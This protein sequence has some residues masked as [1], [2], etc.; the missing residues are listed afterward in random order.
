MMECPS[1]G[2]PTINAST[3]LI[4]DTCGHTKCR[5][6]LLQEES[7]CTICN[8][9]NLEQ[10]APL[11][12]AISSFDYLQP[13]IPMP[14]HV[15]LDS[16][17][18]LPVNELPQVIECLDEPF[19]VKYVIDNNTNN[20]IYKET[21]SENEKYYEENNKQIYNEARQNVHLAFES[22]E[23]VLSHNGLS[24]QNGLTITNNIKNENIHRKDVETQ[25]KQSN[26]NSDEQT[27]TVK[28]LV[29]N[30]VN[31]EVATNQSN[32]TFVLLID[33]NSPTRNDSESTVQITKINKNEDEN[34]DN[35]LP[36]KTPNQLV[37]YKSPEFRMSDYLLFNKQGESPDY[38]LVHKSGD[39]ENDHQLI[40]SPAHSTAY[41][42][43]EFRLSDYLIIKN[44]SD[45]TTYAR[46]IASPIESFDNRV[47]G[48]STVQSNGNKAGDSLNKD[49]EDKENKNNSIKEKDTGSD[50]VIG[51]H[52]KKNR[53]K[54][55]IQTKS[56]KTKKSDTLSS[57]RKSTR[58]R[59]LTAA[60]KDLED[61]VTKNTA[62]KRRKKNTDWSHI[63]KLPGNPVSYE[64]TKCK[65]SFRNFQSKSYHVACILGESPFCCEICGRTFKKRSHFEYHE[66]THSGKKPFMCQDC[67]KGFATK[68]KLDRHML[69]H[70]PQNE[71]ECAEC[72]KKL[73]TKDNL[74]THLALHRNPSFKC[75]HC[76]K[77]FTLKINRKRH[78]QYCFPNNNRYTCDVCSKVFRKDYLL[79][80]HKRR[81]HRKGKPYSCKVCQRVFLSKS[82]VAR[83][84]TIHSDV[85]AFYCELCDIKFRRKDNLK[86]HENNHH[87]S[88]YEVGYGNVTPISVKEYVVAPSPIP[89]GRK[90]QAVDSSELSP[91][92]KRTPKKVK[93]MDSPSKL[94]AASSGDVS[95]AVP[96]IRG[97]ISIKFPDG[98]GNITKKLTESLSLEAAIVLNQQ[99]EQRVHAQNSFCNFPGLS[100]GNNSP[101]S[102]R[103]RDSCNN[104]LNSNDGGS[105]TSNEAQD[106]SK[107]KS[108]EEE[109]SMQHWRRRT[110]EF[111]KSK[112]KS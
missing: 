74:K 54:G 112:K 8:T 11:I 27:E 59:K 24:V 46:L 6:C 41:K 58:K 13:S 104:N 68:S 17:I 88:P 34:E 36:H 25:T 94:K 110:A 72:G 37:M 106:R 21:S 43:P 87:S 65:R 71:F 89:K 73:S 16:P 76:P 80:Q 22:T 44:R 50:D 28:S 70:K 107:Q 98:S 32:I 15:S 108:R 92:P 61:E 45:K 82:E 102:T 23:N 33:S 26:E 10:T 49:D 83:H 66:T 48:S 2:K 55:D 40:L 63:V 86:R 38:V 93:S 19:N 103:R 35:N 30:T 31:K 60:G 14:T 3:R 78:E 42:S 105:P 81:L 20:E 5:L 99:I 100:R 56:K 75:Q 47:S 84:E 91:K 57:T 109:F 1:C 29:V 97:P 101:V 90:R 39:V 95:N 96:V 79:G 4:K 18:K 9:Q 52:E 85:K 53:K 62:V 111:L 64:C 51:D 77:T 69:S 7:G 67:Q 12:A